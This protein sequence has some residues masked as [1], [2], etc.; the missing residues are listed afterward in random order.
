MMYFY[1]L[2]IAI[3]VLFINEY[4]LKRDI[5]ISE[6]GDIHQKFASKSKIPL[7]GGLFIFMGYLY[8]LD[9]KILSFM[10]FSFTI[11]ILGFFSDLKLIKSAKRKFLLQILL[12]LSYVAFN[13]IQMNDT[14]IFFLDVILNNDYIN[15]LFI[16]FCILI[17][18]NGSNFIDGMNTLCI[19]YYFLIG[20]VI[21]YL[22]L[23]GVITINGLSI[24][25]IVI[26]ILAAFLLNITNQLYLGDSGSY[27]LGFSFSV[28]LVG[29]YNWNPHISP[30]FV[31]LLLWYPCYENLFSILRKNILKRSPMYPDAK[32]IHQLIFFYIKKTYNLNIFSAN[33]LTSQII[34]IYNLIIFV[35]GLNFITNTKIQVFLILFNVATYTLAYYKFFKFRYK[36]RV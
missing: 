2:T 3:L 12:V 36:N 30:F 34:N 19:G 16:T 14:R 1:L 25:Y 24:L 8:F 33:T 5:L 15:Y 18:I 17:V 20:F 4:L 35:L 23:E 31:I 32:H 6:T 13:N 26:L 28:F 27:L 9:E 29:I 11:L 7:T 21:F 22:N 10:L